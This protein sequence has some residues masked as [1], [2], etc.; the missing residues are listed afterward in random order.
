MSVRVQ[1]RTYKAKKT[2][3]GL[4]LHLNNK[5]IKSI[6]EIL[7]LDQLVNLEVL[8]LNSNQITRIEG[9]DQLTKI[10]EL[11]L[12]SNLISEIAGLEKLVNLERLS[13]DNNQITRIE[14]LDQLTTLRGLALQG[15]QIT[16]I[17]GLRRLT[18]L[19]GL[20]LNANGIT[21]I[22]GLETLADLRVLQLESNHIAA[23]EGLHH[24]AKLHKIDLAF[25]PVYPR[26]SRLSAQDLVKMSLAQ[27]EH[28]QE[29]WQ[30]QLPEARNLPVE[31]SKALLGMIK[32]QQRVDVNEAAQLLYM[33]PGDV[34]VLL[35]TL[36]ADEK[37]KGH[38]SGDIFLIT[39]DVDDFVAA[40]D[41][42]FK[43]WGAKEKIN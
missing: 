41:Q 14:G 30:G 24:L 27:R 35:F 16:Q 21:K 19:R 43:Q 31:P 38:F 39:S 25:N 3:D 40:L 26:V 36:A 42:Q 17:G 8:D 7:G 4:V 33:T 23:I 5:H 22:Q 12:S 28:E 9:L 10:R 15:N 1:F 2:D 18:N 37:V 13:L 20:Y 6:R 34:R 29:Q 11:D 32:I